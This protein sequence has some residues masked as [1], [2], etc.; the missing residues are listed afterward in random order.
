MNGDLKH[1]TEEKDGQDQTD[2]KSKTQGQ[3]LQHSHRG[4]P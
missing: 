2:L 3:A 1:G 4:T